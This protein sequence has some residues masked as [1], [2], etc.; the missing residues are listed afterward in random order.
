MAF[1]VLKGEL[2]AD[3]LPMNK[4]G[5]QK[6]W[7]NFGSYRLFSTALPPFSIARPWIV[8]KGSIS[9]VLLCLTIPP[10]GIWQSSPLIS[11]NALSI[12][13]TIIPAMLSR[14][15]Q[16]ESLAFCSRV[17]CPTRTLSRRL[18]RKCIGIWA[19]W[20]LRV[21][22]ALLQRRYLQLLLG[23]C[24]TL[25]LMFSTN[26]TTINYTRA[27]LA[28]STSI[29][30]KRESRHCLEGKRSWIYSSKRFSRNNSLNKSPRVCYLRC[31]I[32]LHDDWPIYDTITVSRSIPV[33]TTPNRDV[34]V[35]YG[36]TADP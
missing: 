29:E 15:A 5:N 3:Y 19:A 1:S 11:R 16:Q 31:H 32:P 8:E 10:L 24:E 17:G 7:I 33:Q 21:D 2:S 4:G 34:T 13:T 25:G 12:A 30:H 35:T 23:S 14:V 20:I 18:D 27:G 6:L 22:Y 28:C 26:N 36:S 9:T